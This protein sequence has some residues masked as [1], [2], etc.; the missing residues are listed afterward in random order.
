MDVADESSWIPPSQ[1]REEEQSPLSDKEPDNEPEQGPILHTENQRNREMQQGLT[2]QDNART[3]AT[4]Y[5]DS[6]TTEK[7]WSNK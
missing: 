2:E 5:S 3:T 7:K 6:E 1:N 4:I